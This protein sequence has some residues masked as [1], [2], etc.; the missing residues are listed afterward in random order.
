M[1]EIIY[2][3]FQKVLFFNS[4]DHVIQLSEYVYQMKIAE[5]S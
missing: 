3:H 5:I 2:T 1:V 4:S